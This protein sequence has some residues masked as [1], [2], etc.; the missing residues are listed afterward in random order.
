M[1]NIH[2]WNVSRQLWW[3]HR[4]P[5]W[6]CPDGHITVSD[7]ENGPDACPVCSRAAVEL[8]QEQ[9]IFDTWFSSG[10]W[11]FSTL[12]WPDDTPDLRTYYPTSVMETGYEI[13]F[14]WVARMMMLG[15]WLTG[16]APFHTVYLHGIV[17]DPY[18]SKM[19]KTKGNVVDPLEV[20]E[21]LGAD[22]LRFALLYGP[23]PTQDQ[24]MSRPRLEGARNFANKIWNAARFVLGSRP[25]EIAGDAPLE[26]PSAADLSPADEWILERCARTIEIVERAYAEYQYGLVARTLYDA[27]WSEYCDWYL[28]MAKAGLSADA[29]TTARVATW[30]TLSWV[31]DRYLRLL[32][33]LMPFVTEEI[34]QRTPHLAEDPELLIVAPWPSATIDESRRSSALGVAALIE[35]IG[36]I[37]AARAEAHVHPAERLETR[38]WLPEGPASA[39]FDEMAPVVDRLARISSTRVAQR[40]ALDDETSGAIAVV[41]PS[42]EARLLRS[43]ADRDKDRARLEKELRNVEGQLAAAQRRLADPAFVGRAP[44]NVV[45]QARRR[46]SELTEQT[47]ALRDRL[48]EA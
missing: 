6:Y 33:P 15:E 23:E 47:A 21:E 29:P 10:L 34:W 18:G 13:I 38:L 11:P 17:R 32:H 22:A 25:A 46:V 44:A 3:G 2:D 20:I 31:L 12:G 42:G 27:I 8:T 40:A 5:A 26:P 28:E 24:K 39:A 19:S 36:G 7:E 14:F 9:D 48:D 45:E 37:R 30:Q 41:T 4:I 43:D 35:L 1:E 16:Q